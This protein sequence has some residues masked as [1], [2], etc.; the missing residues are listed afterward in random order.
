MCVH[1]LVP[2]VLGTGPDLEKGLRRCERVKDLDRRPTWVVWEGPES[3]AK[4]VIGHTQ[5]RRRRPP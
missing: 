4:R 3:D 1:V 2:R 5:R